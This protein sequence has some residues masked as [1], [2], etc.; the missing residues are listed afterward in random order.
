MKSIL[1]LCVI[2]ISTAAH[3]KLRSNRLQPSEKDHRRLSGEIVVETFDVG[4]AI[5]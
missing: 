2:L 4:S 3:E 1:L 5:L